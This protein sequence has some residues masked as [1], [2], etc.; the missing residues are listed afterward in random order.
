MNVLYPRKLLQW[1]GWRGNRQSIDHTEEPRNFSILN[2]CLSMIVQQS[3][4]S[5]TG[6]NDDIDQTEAK[7]RQV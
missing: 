6:D 3:E 7:E 5:T 2:Q 1:K 4:Q